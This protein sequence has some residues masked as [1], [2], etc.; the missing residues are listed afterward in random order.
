MEVIGNNSQEVIWWRCGFRKEN[1]EKKW[2]QWILANFSK[3]LAIKIYSDKKHG[4]EE[5]V[6]PRKVC[7]CECVKYGS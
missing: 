3:E 5:N 1:K 4:W 2:S 7:V 6:G